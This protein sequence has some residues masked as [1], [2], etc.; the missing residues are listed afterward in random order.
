MII[1]LVTSFLTWFQVLL[2]RPVSDPKSMF[3]TML[4][5][6]SDDHDGGAD[7]RVSVS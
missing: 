1:A 6:F 7:G 4:I 5:L 3:K 2:V